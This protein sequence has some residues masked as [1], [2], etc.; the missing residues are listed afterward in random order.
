MRF[1]KGNPGFTGK[2]TEETKKKISLKLKGKRHSPTTEFRAGG[3]P[4][5]KG[6]H[7]LQKNNGSP[8]RQGH[9]ASPSTEFKSKDVIGEKNCNWRGGVTPINVKIRG[10][11]TY[12]LWRHSVFKRDKF[13]CQHCGQVGKTMNAHHIKPFSE[14]P[15]LRFEESNG[16]TLCFDCHKRVHLE[17]KQYGACSNNWGSRFARKNIR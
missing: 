17:E 2:H 6:T 11:T 3:T 4:W 13:T 10:L 9:H 16:I 1:Q 12:K 8:F 5:N 15:E 14:Y 7:G